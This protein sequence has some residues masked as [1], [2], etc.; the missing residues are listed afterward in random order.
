MKNFELSLPLVDGSML[1]IYYGNTS[2]KEIIHELITDDFG[3]PPRSMEIT[4]TIESGKKVK[5]YIPYD[6]D[7]DASVIIDGEILK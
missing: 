1:D 5:V 2:G 6:N 3:A 4:V 7:S